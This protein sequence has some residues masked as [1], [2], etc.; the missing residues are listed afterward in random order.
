MDPFVAEIRVFGFKFAP[1]GWA[2]CNG[3]LLP[4]SQNT[5]L[6]ALLGTNFGGDGKSTFGLPDFQGSTAIGQG[7][8]LSS[9]YVGEEGG[10]PNVKLL[11]T[12]IPVH[13]HQAMGTNEPA[14]LQAPGPDRALARSTPGFAW[15]AD[16]ST[17]LAPMN[18]Q[19]TSILGAGLPHENMP[20]AVPLVFCIALEGVYPPRE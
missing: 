18:V 17:K 4:V 10:V 14:E 6:F 12:Q 15:Q 3:Q 7:Q 19:S 9:Y 20:P 11:Q 5:A 16:T 13:T 2:E 1:K 8:G